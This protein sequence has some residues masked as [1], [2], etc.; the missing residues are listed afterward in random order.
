M[1]CRDVIDVFALA[2]IPLMM[3]G[4]SGQETQFLILMAVTV[5]TAEDRS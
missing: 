4:K 2:A 5:A 3:A 1:W